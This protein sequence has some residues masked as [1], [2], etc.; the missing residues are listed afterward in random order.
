VLIAGCTGARGRARDGALCDA[1]EL[2]FDRLQHNRLEA[3]AHDAEPVADTRAGLAV[4][5]ARRHRAEG[6]TQPVDNVAKAGEPV[7]FVLRHSF[8]CL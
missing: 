1:L 4:E 3:G 2:F 6:L 8:S 5:L 7:E